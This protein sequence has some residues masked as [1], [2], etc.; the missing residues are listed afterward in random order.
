M[1]GG[2]TSFGPCS[3]SH[4]LHA[5]LGGSSMSW[6]PP[7]I[8]VKPWGRPDWGAR[9]A[10]ILPVVHFPGSDGAPR[11]ELWKLEMTID[12]DDPSPSVD[13]V[14]HRWWHTHRWPSRLRQLGSAAN[15]SS[16]T[17]VPSTASMQPPR[18]R[19]LRPSPSDNCRIGSP[20]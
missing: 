11:L 7:K 18:D 17:H 1:D 5:I 13:P 12:P 15:P 10:P 4:D 16:W 9:I 2:G 20:S 14:A 8:G 19:Q 3:D 6:L